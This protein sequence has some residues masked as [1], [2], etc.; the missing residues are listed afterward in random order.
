MDCAAN[1]NLGFVSFGEDEKSGKILILYFR[2]KI[3]ETLSLDIRE[4][5]NWHNSL[6]N[7]KTAVNALR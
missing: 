3:V 1:W 2:W 6:L 4:K 5:L 7:K